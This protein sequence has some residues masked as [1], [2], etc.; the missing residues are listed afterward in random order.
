MLSSATPPEIHR[1]S[2]S[3]LK[4]LI[5]RKRADS[6]LCVVAHPGDEIIAAGGS[7]KQWHGA[8][9]IHLTDG[10]PR[11]LDV[12]L[13]AG[14]ECRDEYARAR[15]HEFLEAV[16]CAGLP[17]EN[18]TALGYE[19]GELSPHLAG[20]TMSLASIFHE[21]LA[22]VV[23]T[24]PYEGI[25]PD[26]DA[27]AFAVQAA[28]ALLEKDGITPPTRIEMADHHEEDE[29]LVIGK[30]LTAPPTESVTIRLDSASQQLKRAMFDQ[31][32]TQQALLDGA[33]IHSESFRVAPDYDFTKPPMPGIL[34]YER[35][36]G[37]M[38]GRRWRR[39]AVE[40]LRVL[41]LAHD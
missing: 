39:L 2:P 20:I 32:E 11:D 34:G 37:A 40:A 1:A 9:F 12:A 3:S 25:D 29:Q 41:G 19:E 13:D 17:D 18:I 30:F 33:E 4:S 36:D 27:T 23:I 7:F 8:R 38:N 24:H 21:S 28:C 6:L 35:R 15:G 16:H 31:I 26:H 10:A 22:E 5:F 14:Y